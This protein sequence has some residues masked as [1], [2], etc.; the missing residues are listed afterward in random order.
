[1]LTL[2]IYHT[3]VVGRKII[4][5]TVKCIS[6]FNTKTAVVHC[7]KARHIQ[8]DKESN[9]TILFTFLHHTIPFLKSEFLIV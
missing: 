3:S 4:N 5:W 2:E 7:V 8:G 6:L 9:G 1:M